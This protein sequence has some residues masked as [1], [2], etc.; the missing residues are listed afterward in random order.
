MTYFLLLQTHFGHII[1]SLLQQF[2]G[3]NKISAGQQKKNSPGNFADHHPQKK[4]WGVDWGWGAA[5]HITRTGPNGTHR[6]LRDQTPAVPL[7]GRAGCRRGPAGGGWRPG[8]RPPPPAA[9][10]GVHRKEGSGWGR[11]PSPAQ[12]A[13]KNRTCSKKMPQ[14]CVLGTF[15]F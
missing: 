4:P 3:G 12:S 11:P 7:P 5:S 1:F 14:S 13:K 2:A 8:C 9:G 10:Y 6:G 15:F